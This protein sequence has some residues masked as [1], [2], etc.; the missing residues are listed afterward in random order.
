M[1]QEPYVN[2][3][4]DV[5]SNIAASDDKRSGISRRGFLKYS[6]GVVGATGVSGLLA[7]CSA[8]GHPQF[9]GYGVGK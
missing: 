3:A 2:D 4:L 7:A 5:S 8:G 6:A 9:L 1:S